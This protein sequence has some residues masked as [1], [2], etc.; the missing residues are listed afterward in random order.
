MGGVG[1][2][3][4]VDGMV[5]I[6]VI[7]DDDDLITRGASGFDGVVDAAVNG[8]DSF[9]DGVIYSRVA[10]HVAVGIVHHDEVVLILTDGCNQLVAYLIG[11]HLGL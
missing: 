3:V 1:C 8:F 5:G 7:G 11:T 2:A 4:T 9:S 6:A 10:H